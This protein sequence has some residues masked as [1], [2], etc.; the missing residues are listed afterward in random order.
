[1]KIEKRILG[2]NGD[3]LALAEEKFNVYK[4]DSRLFLYENNTEYVFFIS[5]LIQQGLIKEI[6]SLNDI[7]E[8]EVIYTKED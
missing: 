7:V 4:Y 2:S 6:N 5:D 8:Y 1:M 3:F